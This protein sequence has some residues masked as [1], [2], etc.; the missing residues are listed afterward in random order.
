[1]L[2][3]KLRMMLILTGFHPDPKPYSLYDPI[4]LFT[5]EHEHNVPIFLSS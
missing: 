5:Y 3:M 1:M 2:R 4:F